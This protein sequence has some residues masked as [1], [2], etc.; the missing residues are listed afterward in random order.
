MR[1]DV[2]LFQQPRHAAAPTTHSRC[3]WPVA[4]L[5]VFVGL[6]LLGPVAFAQES[7][8]RVDLRGG[9]L[10]ADLS[11]D[12]RI[13]T[14]IGNIGTSI[15]LENALGFD[16]NSTTYFADGT[17][18]ISRRNQLQVDFEYIKRDVSREFLNRPITFHDTTFNAN[19]SIDAFFDSYYFS[20]Y[21]GFAFVANPSVEIGASIGATVVRLHS[22]IGL[23]AGV[24]GSEDVS[25]DLAEDAR[26]DV[27]VPLP[28]FFVNIR[29]HRRV[30]IRGS[31]RGLKATVNNIS[32]SLVEAKG[33]V[34]V[35]LAGP[36]GV[37]GGYYYNRVRAERDGSRTDGRIVYAFHGPQVYV[38]LG[39]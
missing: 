30:T 25:R 15:N 12:I 9:A 5:G 19:A 20:V 18:R 21:Y 6:H 10:V 37:G 17:W 26:F 22:G 33:G 13:D 14:T 31:T 32:A 2:V 38:V 29:P 27:P 28:G 1:N 39:F 24:G 16:T 7:W 35:K 34:D 3:V 4:T 23:S 36:V 8:P 11:S